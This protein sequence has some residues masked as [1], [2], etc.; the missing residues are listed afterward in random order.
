[1]S[2]RVRYRLLGI[3]MIIVIVL[4]LALTVAF[5]NKAFTPVTEVSVK[6]ER[7][8]LQLLPHSDVKVRGLIVGEVR[9]TD[10]T[11]DG[12]VLHLALDRDKAKLIPNNVQARLLPKTLFGEK[13]VDLQVPA[14]AGPAGLRAG[15]VIQQDRSQTAVE[16]DKVL[17]DLLPLLQAVKPAE[18][19]ATLNALA[20]AL[21]GRGDQIGENIEQADALLK[22]INPQLRTLVHDLHGLADVSDIYAQAAPDLLQTLRNLNVTSRTI[23]SKKATIE[24]LIPATTA[25]AQDGDAFMRH[26]GPKIIGVNIANRDVASLVARYSPSLPCVFAGLMKIKPEAERAAGG[27]GSKTFNLTIEIVKPRP[28]YKNPLDRPEAKDQRNPRCYGL[29]NPKKPFPD[30]LALDGT[31]DDLWWKNPDDPNGGGAGRGRALSNVF[32]DTG[33][34]TPEQQVKSVLGPMTR[35][36]ADELSDVSQLMFGPLL[37]DG[38]VVTIK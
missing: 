2:T 4:L 23:T 30:Y 35:T 33:S 27:G 7:A 20:T 19:N 13:Y 28:G 1:M 36:P 29:P 17:N 18:L 15:Q 24:Q 25:L 32:V 3:S 6:T 31:Q 26:N 5:Y 8:G 22:K 9:G 10:A 12:A 38:S 16:I 11:S 14:Q 37:G 34:L 21:Q